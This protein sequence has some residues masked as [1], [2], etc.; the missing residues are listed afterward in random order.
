MTVMRRRFYEPQIMLEEVRS[1][2][3]RTERID[4]VTFV[5]NGEPTLDAL[6]G[7]EIWL[8]KRELDV[9]VAVLTNSSLLWR[10]DVRRD[11]LEADYVSV[12]IDTA[13]PETWRRINRPHGLLELKRILKGVV[14]FAREYTGTLTTETMLVRG[15]NDSVAE[16]E[17]VAQVLLEIDPE[18]TYVS[19]PVRPPAEPWVEPPSVETIRRDVEVLRETLGSARVGLLAE[20]EEARHGYQGSAVEGL[21]DILAVHP[22]RLD[23]AEN[24]LREAGLD[25]HAVL[26]ELVDKKLVAIVEFRGS[27][28]VVRRGRESALY[29][30]YR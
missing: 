2:L 1:A 24:I 17:R 16:I 14:E 3:L 21:L 19:V 30:E 28:F 5:P 29:R 9:K 8:L 4:Y 11:L 20:L 12:K 6:L 23:Y 15:V 13:S 7:T 25:P 26:T 18:K 27:K 22:L 10:E